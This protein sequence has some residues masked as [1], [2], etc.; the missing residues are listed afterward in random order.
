MKKLFALTL[1]AALLTG[2][3]AAPDRTAAPDDTTAPTEA[4]MPA[5]EP[6]QFRFDGEIVDITL[7]ENE[8]SA[9]GGVNVSRDIIYYE[10]KTKYESGNPYGEGGKEDMHSPEEAAEHLVV[11]ITAPGTYRVS[12]KLEKGQ[13]RVDLGKNAAKELNTIYPSVISSTVLAA[14]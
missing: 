13:I 8:I 14:V 6:P 7:K 11:N 10:E 12:G 2:C 5:A 1:A 3:A 9:G 4:R